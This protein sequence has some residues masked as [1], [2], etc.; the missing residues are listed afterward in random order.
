MLHAISP[1]KK[2]DG[3]RGRG[4]GRK[5]GRR[6]KREEEEEEEEEERKTGEREKGIRT[7]RFC[8]SP[9]VPRPPP[10]CD[11]RVEKGTPS[12]SERSIIV[13]GRVR[14]IVRS[15]HLHRFIVHCV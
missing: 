8:L 1:M 4:G 5:E 12:S 15:G 3:A 13:R 10:N 9:P 6:K 14:M 2:T 7:R 11:R